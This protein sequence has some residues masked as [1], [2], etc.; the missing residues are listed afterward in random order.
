MIQTKLYSNSDV[1]IYVNYIAGYLIKLM[2][3]LRDKESLF[4]IIIVGIKA[5]DWNAPLI[6]STLNLINEIFESCKSLQESFFSEILPSL[7]NLIKIHMAAAGNI[8]VLLTAYKLIL[9]FSKVYFNALEM[10]NEGLLGYIKDTFDFTERAEPKIQLNLDLNDILFKILGYLLMD[11]YTKKKASE[12]FTGK[13]IQDL[14]KE[15]EKARN[16]KPL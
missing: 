15:K 14:K 12:V 13:F 3:E 10:V 7:L 5:Q 9:L 2:K 4:R 6:I 8:E 1:L 16:T 11:L